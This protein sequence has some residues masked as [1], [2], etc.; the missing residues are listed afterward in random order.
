MIAAAKFLSRNSNGIDQE[1]WSGTAP[2]LV[3][4]KNTEGVK[5]KKTSTRRSQAFH[6]RIMTKMLRLTRPVCRCQESC[7]RTVRQKG[8]WTGYDNIR[9]RGGREKGYAEGCAPGVVPGGCFRSG[10][11]TLGLRLKRKKIGEKKFAGQVFRANY[12]RTTGRRRPRRLTSE[13]RWGV[14]KKKRFGCTNNPA[15]GK[16]AQRCG[17][18]VL[19]NGLKEEQTMCW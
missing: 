12:R 14:S 15:E 2:S 17:L 13:G 4:S 6:G 16:E 19:K 10:T 1:V 5:P 18:H 8:P 11:R 9:K 7:L 3:T